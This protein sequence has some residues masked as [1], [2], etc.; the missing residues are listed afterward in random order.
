MSSLDVATTTDR[1]DADVR[2]PLCGYDLRGLVEPR[3]PECGYRFTWEEMRDPA[4]R[5]HPYLFEH[6]PERNVWSFR[7][8]LLGGLRPGRFWRT[9][10]P[11]QP[12]R[13]RRLI[14]YWLIASLFATLP[15]AVQYVRHAVQYQQ[16]ALSSRAKMGPMNEAQLRSYALWVV[17]RYGSAQAYHDTE[18]PLWPS[19]RAALKTWRYMS[20]YW[21]TQWAAVVLVAWPWLT[22]ATLMVFQV[23]MRRVRVRPIHVLRCV[24]YAG[25]VA[26]WVGLMTLLVIGIEVYHFRSLP[27]GMS[28]WGWALADAT[29]VGVVCAAMLLLTVRLAFA[30]RL[31][32]RFAQAAATALASQVM[33]GLV[34]YILFLNWECIR[35]FW[36]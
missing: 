19:P 5:L 3:C 24:L 6:H 14:A 33:V 18:L 31:Y 25:D 23:S 2:C 21:A 17:D 4:R 16:M 11:A 32:L 28:N 22:F 1:S 35:R 15:A 26:V 9:L 36:W 34:V 10:F 30:Y 20:Y 27:G 7:K 13:P 29:T 8:T 12:S